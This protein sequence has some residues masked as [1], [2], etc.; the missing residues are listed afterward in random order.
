MVNRLKNFCKFIEC[1]HMK[2]C[3]NDFTKEVFEQQ[4]Q[5]CLMTIKNNPQNMNEWGKHNDGY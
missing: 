3:E 1:D 2:E 5:T 4:L